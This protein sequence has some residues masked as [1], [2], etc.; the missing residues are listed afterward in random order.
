MFVV[1]SLLTWS[2]ALRLAQLSRIG[3]SDQYCSC[4]DLRTGHGTRGASPILLHAPTKVSSYAPQRARK[5]CCWYTPI[6]G[7][8]CPNTRKRTYSR[9]AGNV[10]SVR[11]QWLMAT[12]RRVQR[13][14][15][16]PGLNA[17]GVPRASDIAISSLAPPPPRVGN[18]CHDWQLRARLF[19]RTRVAPHPR[20][21]A[22]ARSVGNYFFA[23]KS[24]P[25]A[26][27]DGLQAEVAQ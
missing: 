21:V 9:S 17:H 6:S 12:L 11:V 24:I 1:G 13:T 27:A 3:R 25:G 7:R 8:L 20:P 2:I 14:V 26:A 15:R 10:C 19:L 5:L 22:A 23:R 4:G 18:R 16:L